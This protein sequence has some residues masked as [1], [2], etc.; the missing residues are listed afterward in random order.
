MKR[1]KAVIDG[2]NA[3]Y[4][5]A[6]RQP[7]ANMKNILAVVRAVQ[8]AGRDPIV[9][10]DPTNRSII[11][12]A[13]KFQAALADMD[14]IEVMTVPPGEE[15]DRVV[16]QTADHYNA[17]IVSNNTYAQYYEDYPWVEE[18]RIPIALINGTIHLLEHRFSRAS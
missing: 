14:D 17:S 4:L 6:P 3:A 13:A 11:A 7:R 18:R 12:D 10:I 9:V 5:E 15:I 1:E 16:L 8:A 2:A